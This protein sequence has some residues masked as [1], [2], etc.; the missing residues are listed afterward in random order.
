MRPQDPFKGRLLIL[1]EHPVRTVEVENTIKQVEAEYG[2]ELDI[3]VGTMIE[4]PRAAIMSEEI[5]KHADF[6]S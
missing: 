3:P 1:G 5:T 2:V 4:L 6:F